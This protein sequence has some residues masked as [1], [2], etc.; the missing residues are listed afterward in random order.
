MKSTIL[1]AALGAAM[2]CS[3]TSVFAH[4][5][6]SVQSLPFCPAA[7]QC[8]VEGG[9]QLARGATSNAA[10]TLYATALKQDGPV[11]SNDVPEPG[12]LALMGVGALAVG[13]IS[14]RYGAKKP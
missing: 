2:L 8:V 6:Q 12:S 3:V 11:P 4:L 9:D 1:K 5:A 13:Y 10:K 14:R 7:S